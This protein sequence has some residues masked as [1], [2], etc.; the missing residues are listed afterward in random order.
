MPDIKRPQPVPL[1]ARCAICEDP[2][3][4]AD[5]LLQK[6]AKFLA[7]RRFDCQRLVEQM[8]HSTPPQFNALL[9]FHRQ[10]IRERRAQEQA[11]QQHQQHINTVEAEQDQS[12]LAQWLSQQPAPPATPPF[13]IPLPLGLHAG[14]PQPQR[15][16]DAYRTYLEGVIE[17][18]FAYGSV[19]AVPQDQHADALHKRLAVDA[20]F[21]AA[22]QLQQVSDQLCAQCKGG[23]CSQGGDH[24]F[25]TAITLRRQIDTDPALTPATLL[26]RYLDTLPEHSMTGSCIHQS[27]QGCSLP[28]PLRSDVCNGFYCEPLRKL[29]RQWTE[30]IPRQLF[31]VQRDNHCWNRYDNPEGNTVVGTRLIELEQQ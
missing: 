13:V 2:I 30:E 25:V 9:D 20:L 1:Q 8:R 3:P 22:P 19:E 29:H 12:L 27:A 18:A 31:V 21:S 6:D 4:V 14:T 15:R 17:Q 10:Q 28:R 11:C 24:A 7:C 16:R 26:Q 23:C 5:L